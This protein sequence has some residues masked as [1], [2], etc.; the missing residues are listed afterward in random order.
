[1]KKLYTIL[2][3]LL[4]NFAYAQIKGKVTNTKN[5]ALPYVN[6]YLKNALAGT[7]TNDDGLYQ[8]DLKKT[9]NYT[10]IFQF[11]G[12]KTL[13]KQVQIKE[14]PFVLNITLT[15]EEITLDEVV[16]S[17][18]E[19]PANT[20]IRNVI[21]NKEKNT[22]KWK[23]YTARFYSRGLFKIKNAP[24]SF[25]G[26][27]IEFPFPLDSTRSG[28]IYLSETVSN[29]KY[30]KKPKQF[31]E[32]IVASKVSGRD[33]G[34]SLNQAQDVN[35]NFYENQIPIINAKLFSPISNYAFSYYKYK[36]VGSF[37]E[38]GKLINKIKIIPKNENDR[39]FRGFIYIT[40]NDWQLYG[41]N[42]TVNGT[43]IGNPA[44]KVLH[45]KQNYNYN[46]QTD[47]WALIL[48]TIDFKLGMFGFKLS[49]RFSASYKNYNFNP[50]FTNKSFD[51]TILSFE[52]NATKK[53][54][55]YWNKLRTVPLTSEEKNDYIIK[56]SV[57]ILQKTKPYLDSIDSKRNKIGWLSP[58]TGYT[59]QNSYKKWQL[60]YNG[61][62]DGFDYNTVQGFAPTLALNYTK[63]KNDY[64]NRWTIGT[65]LNYGFSDKKLR[66]VF[67]FT[68]T[69]NNFNKPF[70]Q[71]SVGNK[72]TQFDDRNPITKLDNAIYTLLQKENFAKYYEKNFAKINFGKEVARGIQFGTSLEYAKRKPLFNSTNYSF[73]KR[74]RTFFTNNPV[75]R[76]STVA[77]FNAHTI[78]IGNI[79]ATFN[80]KSKYIEYPN[81][82]F[83]VKNNSFPTLSVGY[84]KTFGTGD[85]NL[86]SNLIWSR[87]QQNFS[88]G[89]IGKFQYNARAGMFLKRKNIPFIDYY[90]PLGNKTIFSPE[91]R[92]SS[93][94]RLSYYQLSTNDKYAE[95]HAE[96]N[97]EGFLLGK[98]PLLKKLNF[99]TV[100][101]GKSYF[102]A[103]TKPYTEYG[104]GLTNIGWGKWR[105]L[106]V[107]YVRSNFNGVN[108]GNF[109][110]GI[111][112]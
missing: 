77:P 71:V 1:M 84:R 28:I 56:D 78:F 55:A 52:K 21:K 82:R 73:F 17:S 30:Q 101:F 92:M 44:I 32:H 85:N 94:Y 4:C 96:H 35:F 42:V 100:I 80:F 59:Y 99:H 27:K 89:N 14:F 2:L 11:L 102:S 51:N 41:T 46:Q 72:V 104:I 12:Y 63:R 40:E 24:K 88:L 6:V 58:L 103:N 23:N 76:I 66:P 110:F 107:D 34:V 90:H 22:E 69:W 29:I 87:L 79:S 105:L 65:K 81:R 45:I 19:N 67:S 7:T 20:I 112:F 97:F 109:M 49:G 31:K 75:N 5:Q 9:G 50:N 86:H 53:D 83:T 25:M 13:K 64:G 93:F 95:L 37:Y 74:E 106:R 98:I 15:P 54:S 10:I 62:I 61:I 70:V 26:Q 111:S 3:I 47:S 48:Q 39:V 18:T 60:N 36:L 108:N 16:V 91:S 8:L 68:K 43:Q 33:N 57:K 38:N